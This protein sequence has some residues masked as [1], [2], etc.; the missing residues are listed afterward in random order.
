MIYDYFRVVGAHATVL[1]YADLF[2]ITVRNDDFQEFDT[3]WDEIPFSM[4]NIPSDDVLESLYKLR[5]RES[6]QLKTVLELYDM[7]IHQM[8][9]KPNYQI[10][11][12]L[13]LRS[14]DARNERIETGRWLRDAGVNV[15]LKEDKEFAVH[16]RQKGQCWRGDKCIFRHDSDEREKSTPRATPSSEPPTQGGRSAPRKGASEAGVLL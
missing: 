16:S 2:S 14:C 12:K 4:T 13:R 11:Q 8:I 6:D 10:V 15:V 3:R 7:E 9:A 1:D 5:I